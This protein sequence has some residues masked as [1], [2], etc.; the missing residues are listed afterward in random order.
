MDWYVTEAESYAELFLDDDRR[1]VLTSSLCTCDVTPELCKLGPD[2]ILHFATDELCR[3]REQWK[4]DDK[5]VVLRSRGAQHDSPWFELERELLYCDPN[6]SDLRSKLLSFY[7]DPR[8]VPQD[9]MTK[10]FTYRVLTSKVGQ[11]YIE[12]EGFLHFIDF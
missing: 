5:T 7:C 4:Q 2:G 6:P 9:G 11:R 1:I 12:I 10:T 3:K 8:R